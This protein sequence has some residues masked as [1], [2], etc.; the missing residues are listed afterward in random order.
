MNDPRE[1]SVHAAQTIPGDAGANTRDEGT[2][3]EIASESVMAEAHRLVY[4]DRQDD[5]GP[6]H[7]EME[8]VGRMWS[9]ILGVEVT[10]YQAALCMSALK[11]VRA[12]NA[13]KRDNLV[14]GCGYLGLA[15]RVVEGR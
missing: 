5:Y 6:G 4:G 3:R 15:Q 14:D 9:V 7:V 1:A 10:G 8:M 2:G 11:I 13:Y 12:S